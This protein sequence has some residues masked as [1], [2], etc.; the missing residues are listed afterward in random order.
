MHSTSTF[1]YFG[2]PYN[3]LCRKLEACLGDYHNDIFHLLFLS[4]CLKNKLLLIRVVGSQNCV[5]VR[6]SMSIYMCIC[7]RVGKDMV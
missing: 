5:R 4:P 7:V 2:E 3:K 6:V 1:P